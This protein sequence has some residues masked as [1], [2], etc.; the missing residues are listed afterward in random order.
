MELAA[1][2][3]TK[4][5]GAEL[6]GVDLRRPLTQAM[7]DAIISAIEIYGVCVFHDTRLNDET[8]IA[9][10]HQLGEVYVQPKTHGRVQRPL[11]PELFEAGNLGPDNEI[12]RSPI[13]QIGRRGNE[14]WHTDHSF[15]ANRSAYSLLLAHEIPEGQGDTNFADTRSAYEALP[16]EMKAKLEGLIAEHSIWY[17]RMT[18][19]YPVTED[20]IR[21]R[22]PYASHPLVH[23]HQGS[24]RKALYIASHIREVDGIETAQARA[25]IKELIEFATQPQFTFTH[26]WREGDLVIWDNRCTMHC[27]TRFEDEEKRRD[28]RRTNILDPVRLPVEIVRPPELVD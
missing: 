7:R 19:G 17:S 2:R 10:S 20:E 15:I 5:F 28:L 6:S 18:A 11:A 14:Q 21:D 4:N 1:R 8:H 23:L 25:M 9:F 12:L 16:Q 24:G 27:A 26:A 13:A 3:I 22:E